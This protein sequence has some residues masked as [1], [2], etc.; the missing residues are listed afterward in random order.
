MVALSGARRI[1][2]RGTSAVLIGLLAAT[3]S[4][5]STSVAGRRL[6]DPYLQRRQENHLS[7]WLSEKELMHLISSIRR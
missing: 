1:G 4:A 7:S 3:T 2:H 6:H 5:S